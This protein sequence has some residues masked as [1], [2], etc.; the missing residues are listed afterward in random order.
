MGNGL[1]KCKQLPFNEV[2]ETCEWSNWWWEQTYHSPE[3]AGS[4]SMSVVAETVYMGMVVQNRCAALMISQ[5]N[6]QMRG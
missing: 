5:C 2:S 3:W 6:E 4:D 1:S